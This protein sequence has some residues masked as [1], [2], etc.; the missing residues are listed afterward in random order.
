MLWV[1]RKMENIE[2]TGLIDAMN[3]LLYE[4]LLECQVAE[5]GMNVYHKFSTES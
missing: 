3:L 4:L 1:P 2:E 5:I